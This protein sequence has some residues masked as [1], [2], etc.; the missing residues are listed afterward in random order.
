MSSRVIVSLLALP[1]ILFWIC[2]TTDA[3]HG[4]LC[5]TDSNCTEL[6]DNSTCRFS[7]S[8]DSTASCTGVCAC[9]E[10]FTHVNGSC[11][12]IRLGDP[13]TSN[14]SCNSSVENSACVNGTCEC[15]GEYVMKH[16]NVCSVRLLGDKCLKTADCNATVMYSQCHKQ[17]KICR[18]PR[19]FVQVN[20]NTCKPV[21][22]A[23]CSSDEMCMSIPNATCSK[24]PTSQ[25]CVR[26][27]QC[28][29]GFTKVNG[30]CVKLKIGDG[31]ELFPGKNCSQ[32]ISNSECK[33]E[34][35]QC[36]GGYKHRQ[37]VCLLR[38]VG[39][40]CSHNEDCEAAVDRSFC[41]S[42]SST[43]QCLQGYISRGSGVACDR[44]KIG[45]QCKSHEDCNK[46]VRNSRCTDNFCICL[47]DYS[48]N[49]NKTHCL[50]RL[51]GDPCEDETSCANV[52]ESTCNQ[53]CVCRPGFK[54]NSRRRCEKRQLGDLCT[55]HLDCANACG[56]NACACTS[57]KCSKAALEETNCSTNYDCMELFNNSFCDNS[58][59]HCNVNLAPDP[60]FQKCVF[61]NLGHV[62][63]ETKNRCEYSVNNSVCFNKTCQCK[64]THYPMNNS[65]CS[66][67]QIG[68]LKCE[69]NTQCKVNNSFCEMNNTCKCKVGYR[70]E[71]FDACVLASLYDECTKP[72]DCNTTILHS[73]CDHGRC[74]CLPGYTP[75]ITTT[76]SSCEMRTLG[77]GCK[78][79][80]DCSSVIENSVCVQCGPNTSDPQTC[81]TC[82]CKAGYIAKDASPNS[83]GRWLCVSRS[84]GDPCH[85]DS[86]CADIENSACQN[87]CVCQPGYVGVG[88]RRCSRRESG[89]RTLHEGIFSTPPHHYKS[90]LIAPPTPY[91]DILSTLPTPYMD[92]LSTPPTPYKEIISH[93]PTPYKEILSTPP[94]PYKE[95]ISPPPTP[96]KEIISILSTPNMDIIS[97]SSPL[98]KDFLLSPPRAYLY[99]NKHPLSNDEHA[100]RPR[101]VTPRALVTAPTRPLMTGAACSTHQD[102]T[103][104]CYAPICACS[105]GTCF[106]AALGEMECESDVDC[107]V[108][109][110]VCRQQSCTC[111]EGYSEMDVYT[112][113][114]YHL[115]DGCYDNS[116]CANSV[117][118]SMCVSFKCQ[119]QDTYYQDDAKTCLLKGTG[120][121]SDSQ[122][123]KQFLHSFCDVDGACQC[124]I[125]YRKNAVGACAPVGLGDRCVSQEECNVTNPHSECFFNTCVCVP[126]Y[127][128]KHSDQLVPGQATCLPT[129]LG[130]ACTSSQDCSLTIPNSYCGVC[131]QTSP[132]PLCVDACRRL[133]HVSSLPTNCSL[134]A[135][136]CKDGFLEMAGNQCA[137]R[138]LSDPCT[139]DS[140]CSV[141]VP[142]A[143]CVSKRCRCG[144]GYLQTRNNTFCPRKKI[145]DFC[146]TGPNDD[147]SKAVDNS[148]CTRNGTKAICLCKS[149]YQVDAS[150][151]L[152]RRRRIREQTCAVDLDCRDAVN[153]SHCASG[154]CVCDHGYATNLDRD[155]CH[156]MRLH[157]DTCTAESECSTAVDYSTCV[158]GK[159][160]CVS[161]FYSENNNTGCLKRKIGIG[162]CDVH[163]DCSDAV[164]NSECRG[165]CRC[166]SGY[167]TRNDDATTCH[168]RVIY[169]NCTLDT[170]CSDAV[171]DTICRGR[172]CVCSLGFYA[173]A[174]NTTCIKRK[175]GDRCSFNL[176]C[177]MVTGS[178]GCANGTCVCSQGY[179][180]HANSTQCVKAPE[181]LGSECEYDEQ[182]STR[183]PSS[184]GHSTCSPA[185]LTCVCPNGTFVS[186]DAK[187]CVKLPQKIGDYC[188]DD[189]HCSRMANNTICNTTSMTSWCQCASGYF[190]DNNSSA[191]HK[192]PTA[193]GDVCNQNEQCSVNITHSSCERGRVYLPVWL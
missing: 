26:R 145:G 19:F 140:D 166:M 107:T 175:L 173:S 69:S 151:T 98:Y 176:D 61:Y 103:G 186:R 154:V 189:T 32:T 44:V 150:M 141:H 180:G 68:G 109:N 54:P 37:D 65:I 62:C 1:L 3:G 104:M 170:D 2:S 87:T 126:G 114:F 46:S 142:N 113:R 157:T 83:T 110:S 50:E 118:H 76:T 178:S 6:D 24:C 57:G 143:V 5:V 99:Q 190:L 128:P 33:N 108:A 138:V 40:N 79:S 16:E 185:T 38:V 77:S 132:D 183:F 88:R 139:N 129:T 101:A 121:S 28:F 45:D 14:T 51:L 42:S 123:E 167:M 59:C 115:G 144:G 25:P 91:K 52:K 35:C 155:A 124:V 55:S 39:D 73:D 21:V 102:C 106:D 117:M 85:D 31:C 177:Q 131:D 119:C 53:T 156:R 182:C 15:G 7:Q 112:C 30:S 90:V 174:D 188:A 162:K 29:D 159:C 94:T 111:D 133:M 20:N 56:G 60:A 193:L 191:C 84:L 63:S 120:C 171:A 136:L 158:N 184:I 8:C 163:V 160:A 27:C 66:I 34:T 105:R 81:L 125:G 100:R 96:Y 137:P 18:C 135:C 97:A 82:Q 71:G 187:A 64:D 70:Q 165:L 78:H 146:Y 164:N 95:T 93:P 161:G 67:K 9:V 89:I 168:R 92:I 4:D 169:D 10:G 148:V 80:F 130:D 12:K 134:N 22:D 192:L 43:C 13:C 149:G 147:C 48:S 181:R 17:T 86:S 47:K 36:S 116:L 75:N 172:R 72:E 49:R 11:V 127:S 41:N 179:D 74:R 152:C 122:C 58:T 153:M 23:P